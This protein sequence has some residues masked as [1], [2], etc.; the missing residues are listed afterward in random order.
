MSILRRL[1]S[2]PEQR[3]TGI[4]VKELEAAM[5]GSSGVYGQE[6]P[7]TLTSVYRAV[8]L[9]ATTAASLPLRLY[10]RDGEGRSVAARHPLYEILHTKP[11]PYQTA[12]AF[13]EA[14]LVDALLTGN[15]YAHIE[16][17]RDGQ[18]KA[19]W[20]L[21]ARRVIM[22]VDWNRSDPIRYYV[23]TQKGEGMW[24]RY[25]EVLH[26]KAMGDG[27][28]G[29]SPLQLF[30]RTLNIGVKSEQFGEAFYTQGAT[31]RVVIE[32][33][34]VL[35][36]E[37]YDRLKKSL[38]DSWQGIGNAHKAVILEEGMK[39]Q[40]MQLAP[41]EAQFLQTRKMTV[42]EV[43]RIFGVPP[44]MLA[45]LDKAT[46]SNIE[47]LSIEFVTHALRPWL[48][49]LES[50]INSRLLLPSDRS[51]Y[52]A[53]HVV[54]G[55][56]RGDTA[57]RYSA[58]A[59]ARQ[60]GW[61]SVN[62]IR[63]LENMTPIDEGDIY[64]SPLNMVPS[65]AYQDG[66]MPGM[67]RDASRTLETRS[68]EKIPSR[69][70]IATAMRAAL[71]DVYR[72][73]VAREAGDLRKKLPL[74]TKDKASFDTWLQEWRDEMTEWNQKR[75]DPVY[76][77]YAELMISSSAQ[78]IRYDRDI[79][80]SEIMQEVEGYIQQAASRQSRVTTRLVEAAIT[81]AQQDGLSGEDLEGSVREVV[82]GW[83]ESRSQTVAEDER[84]RAAGAFA[85]MAFAAMGISRLKWRTSGSETCPTCS[86]LDGKTVGIRDAFVQEGSTV[87]E[88]KINSRIGHPPLHQGCDCQIMPE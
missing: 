46:Y 60:W 41:E 19:L 63:R 57:Q 84:V 27:L 53:E 47:H 33:P 29:T 13:R 73:I 71:E 38:G 83:P 16:Y 58:Y 52:Y 81:D 55:L 39:T 26:I 3:S 74:L 7:H 66:Q 6:S 35:G 12:M 9:I 82:D 78:E 76:R 31:P 59:V 85:V 54:E 32:H 51:R 18:V 10:Q 4:T 44:H 80:T 1:L 22:D 30:A 8:G 61:L 23:G 72:R 64:L 21:V 11:N 88:M 25:E 17:G 34:G 70:A 79:P 62:E 69:R 28:K 77:S 48:V 24:L 36:D 37:A 50:D 56:L 43:A 15:G 14:L 40:R 20:P 87:G 42:N 5:G 49:R 86:R 67:E 75:L 65:E 2:A 68:D 45:D